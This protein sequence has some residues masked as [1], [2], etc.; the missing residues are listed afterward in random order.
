MHILH[1]SKYYHPYRGGI[2]K[3]I[4]ELSEV[5]VREGHQVTV[6]CASETRERVEEN[7]NGVTVLRLPLWGRVFSQ[8][9]T[10]TVF[11]ELQAKVNQA[12]V[13]HLHTPNPLFE[14]ACLTLKI[15]C[16]LVVTYHCEVMK[17]RT[18]NNL[19]RPIAK[20]VLKRADRIL[21][22]TEFHLRYSKWLLPFSHKCEIIP[23]GIA[24]K[25]QLKDEAGLARLHEI[26]QTYD[27]YF[28]FIGRM[29][30]YK[31][32]Y[33]LLEAMKT[34]DHNLVLIGKGPLLETWKTMSEQLGVS[35]RVHFVGG[36]EDE[37]FSAFLNGC[38][39]VV[40]PSVNEAEAFGLALIE[41]M[42]CKKPMITTSLKS[43]VQFVNIAKE[44]GLVVPPSNAKALSMA[45]NWMFTHNE[46][47]LRMGEN[48]LARFDK[49]FLIDQCF[50]SHYDVYLNAKATKAA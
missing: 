13:V 19:Y 34:V 45:M 50:H 17:A 31:G 47:R 46:D 30:S 26:K 1:L 15:E 49:Y 18:L 5:A 35:G 44:T 4:K 28:L 21:I 27:R 39:A 23:F 37:D 9:L 10:P 36:V 11:W 2:E 48:A 24:P 8:P 7:V 6:V 43:G 20:A 25:H 16:P 14:A 3:V 33:V 41:G 12:D 22:A 38:E 42:S 40:L 29:V 32:V